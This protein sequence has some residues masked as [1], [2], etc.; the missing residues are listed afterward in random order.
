[1]MNKADGGDC[2][3]AA[4][5]SPVSMLHR[6]DQILVDRLVANVGKCVLGLQETRKGSA[7]NRVWR[8]RLEIAY[9]I[10]DGEDSLLK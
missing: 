5:L 1:M 3:R 4:A 10:L 9:R 8:K 6:D 7:E 2:D